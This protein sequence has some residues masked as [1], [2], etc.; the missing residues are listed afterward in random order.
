MCRIVLATVAAGLLS[1]SLTAPVIA[2]T[3]SS[4]A[5]MSLHQDLKI[6][7]RLQRFM[8]NYGMP[9]NPIAVEIDNGR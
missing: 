2:K 7:T 4:A 9:V 6:T 1:A 8:V 3:H 5:V